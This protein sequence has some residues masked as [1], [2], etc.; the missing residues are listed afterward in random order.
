MMAMQE[1]T[2]REVPTLGTEAAFAIFDSAAQLYLGISGDEF[3]RR[4]NRNELGDFDED[5]VSAV[6]MLVPA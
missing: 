2:T 5:A 1:I 3:L 6:L 4:A